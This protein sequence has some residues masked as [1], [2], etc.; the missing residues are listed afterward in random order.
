MGGICNCID[1]YYGADCSQVYCTTGTYFNPLTSACVT[2]CPSGY[3]Q[4]KYDSSCQ[5]C[6]SS[7]QQCYQEPTV[8]TGCISTA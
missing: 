6:H 1:G 3:Y 5:K 8:C 2:I 7:C 4:N